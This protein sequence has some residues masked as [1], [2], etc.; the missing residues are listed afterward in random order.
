MTLVDTHCHLFD[1]RLARDL[2]GV[3]G[4]ALEAGV[5][6][7]VVP[8]VTLETSREAV[9][10]SERFD[11]VW[12][13][14]GIHPE[15]VERPLT[16]RDL[17]ALEALGEHPRVVAIGEV[18]LDRSPGRPE[19]A[20]QEQV[21]RAQVELARSMGLALLVHS[22]D[23]GGRTLALLEELV[24]AEGAIEAR[25]AG[26]PHTVSP[27]VGSKPAGILHAWAGA[28][29]LARAFGRLGFAFGVAGV[30]CRK[31]AHRVR[32]RLAALPLGSL[33]LETDAPYIGTAVRPRGQV[34]PAHLPEVRDALGELL[35]L[36]PS[37][38]EEATTAKARALLGLAEGLRPC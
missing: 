29:E 14:V 6:A 4:R 13:G 5:T 11:C 18:G 24:Q 28:P 37:R 16:D 32:A 25:P 15:A 8:G 23:A 17:A 38:V 3:V 33:V 2:E 36:E 7:L 21:F 34:E 35:G 22:R 10:L 26:S 31:A 19:L 20:L 1:E 12:A 9:A 27:H 30:V